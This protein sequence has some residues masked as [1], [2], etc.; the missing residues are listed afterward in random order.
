[1]GYKDGIKYALGPAEEQAHWQN[2]YRRLVDQALIEAHGGSPDASVAETRYIGVPTPRN[3]AIYKVRG[4]AEFVGNLLPE[5]VLHGRFVRSVHPR[6][7]ILNVDISAARSAPGVVDVLT[8]GDL[9]P[10]RSLVGTLQHDTPVLAGDQVRYVGEP[11]AAIV[12]ETLEQAEAACDL[13][14]V[15]YEPL[16][17]V[18]TF[19]DALAPDA[20]HVD[21]AGNTICDY[22]IGRGDI[23]AGFAEADVV[24]E[25]I[26]KTEPIDHCFMEAQAGIAFVDDGGVLTLLCCTQYPHYHQQELSRIT[27]LPLDKVRVIQTITGGGFGGKLDATIECVASLLALRTKRPIKMTLSREEVFTA[28]TKRHKSEIHQKLGAT[29]DGKLTACDVRILADGGAYRSYSEIVAGRMMVHVGMPYWVPNLRVHL[30][31]VFTNHAPS[32]A[33]RSFGVVKV[34]FANESL[35]NELAAKLGMSP[36]EIRRINGFTDG[37]ETNTG[38]VLQD[39]GLH[40]T[41]DEIERIYEQRKRELAAAPEPGRKIGLGVASLAYGIGY[42]GYPNPAVMT[43]NAAPDGTITAHVGTPDFGTGSD[44]VFA[45]VIAETTG[46]SIKRILVRS[47]D[48][49][50]SQDAGPTSASRLTYFCGNAAHIS[51]LDFKRKF[52]AAFAEKAGSDP[53]DVELGDDGIRHRNAHIGFDEACALLGDELGDIEGYGKFDPE[54]GVNLETFRGNPYPTYTYATHLVEAEI[55]D[56]LGTVVVRRYWAAHDGGRIVNPPAAEGQVE[57]GVAMGLGMALW[58]RVAREGGHTLNP[59]YRD[60]LLAGTRDIPPKF[61]VMFVA[62]RDRTGPYGA[63]GIAESTLIPAPPA[64]GAAIYDAVGVRPRKLPMDSEYIFELIRARDGLAGDPK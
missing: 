50:T 45:Q 63:K 40:K 34:G 17:P 26:F 12:A 55:D 58:E 46:I 61:E 9:D 1:M 48:S 44:T 5:G 41:L 32:G 54:A 20:P 56:E 22:N 23:E 13:V 3:D 33:M 47:G 16:T 10:E 53:A 49:F 14:E 21:E 19:E 7:R 38:Q 51:G 18:L 60:Y 62:N 27:G 57:G 2:A 24:V 30:T 37:S 43:I 15:D 29:K 28:T 6:A 36:I 31:T 64:L 25:G 42:T 35:I 52:E 59:N 8:A 4:R 11:I 39:V